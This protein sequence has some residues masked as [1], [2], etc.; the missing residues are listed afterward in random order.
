MTALSHKHP[1]VHMLQ[2]ECNDHGLLGALLEIWGPMPLIVQT[3]NAIQC[4]KAMS[5]CSKA[6]LGHNLTRNRF[7]SMNDHE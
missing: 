7:Y 3:S 4:S 6:H 2:Q 1:Y 5:Q